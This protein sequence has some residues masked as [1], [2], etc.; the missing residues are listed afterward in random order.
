MKS[1][2]RRNCRAGPH[3]HAVK[4]KQ[5]TE[6]GHRC[7]QQSAPFRPEGQHVHDV[8]L[9]LQISRPAPRSTAQMRSTAMVYAQFHAAGTL[10]NTSLS[11]QLLHEATRTAHAVDVAHGADSASTCGTFSS[12][13]TFPDPVLSLRTSAGRGMNVSPGIVAKQYADEGHDIFV[14]P[15]S[16]MRTNCRSVVCQLVPESVAMNVISL[17]FTPF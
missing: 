9:L 16:P 2:L 1:P 12:S 5:K 14:A 6:H 8:R 17:S 7:V 13:V 11:L 10:K 4:R 15:D 3:L